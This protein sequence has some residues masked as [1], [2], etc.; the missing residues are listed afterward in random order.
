MEEAFQT[1]EINQRIKSDYIGAT[2]LVPYPK[3]GV[4]DYAIER[5]LLPPDFSIHN[6]DQVMRRSIIKSPY[7]REFENLCALF[8][9]TVKFPFIDLSLKNS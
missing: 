6:F 8:N 9:L 2:V 1:I 7:T 4:V 3:T 5:G